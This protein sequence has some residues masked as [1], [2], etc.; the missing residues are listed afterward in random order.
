MSIKERE[1][2]RHS[3]MHQPARKTKRNTTV[4]SHYVELEKDSLCVVSK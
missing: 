2:E 4:H 3:F 1:R